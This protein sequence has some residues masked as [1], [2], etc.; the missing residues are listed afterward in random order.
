[1]HESLSRE[2]L[3][4]PN[5]LPAVITRPFNTPEAVKVSDQ[6]LA[7]LLSAGFGREDALYAYQTLRAYVL[8]YA[9][10]E[11]VGLIVD[12]PKWDNRGRMT[13]QDY[14]DHGF[15]HLLEVVPAPPP[16]ITTRSSQAGSTR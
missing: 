6:V 11:T 1:M 3:A 16:T 9:L 10:T 5:L 15:V 14:G 2:L 7:I 12:P 8:G 4:H 13:I